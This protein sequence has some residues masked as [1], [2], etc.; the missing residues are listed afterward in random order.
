ML[1]TELR[2]NHIIRPEMPV[3]R[4]MPVISVTESRYSLRLARDAGEIDAALKLRFEV[5]NLEL[6]EGLDASFTTMRDRDR[7]DRQCH[8]LLVIENATGMVVG[9]YRMQTLAIAL[10]GEGFYSSELFDLSALPLEVL[11]HTIEVGRACIAKAHRNGRVLY[12][13]WKGIA[14]YMQQYHKRYLFGC[15]SLTSQDPF[16]GK[17]L[18]DYLEAHNH[19]HPTL[20]VPPQPG[21]ECYPGYFSGD[22]H[23][24]VDIPR[25]LRTYLQYGAKIC[26]PPALDRDFKTIDFF[27]LLDIAQ[28]NRKTYL[29]FFS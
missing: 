27:V 22:L 18:M 28:F 12:L 16:D 19:R 6:G 24:S 4:E 9:T 3:S 20:T 5:F 17:S 11:E 15:C 26:G 7:Y 14:R 10:S 29:V 13:L 8:H 1:N 21:Y 25:L 2:Q 23:H